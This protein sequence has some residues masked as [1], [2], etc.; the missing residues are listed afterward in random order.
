MKFNKNLI[1]FLI[2]CNVCFTQNMDIKILHGLR[3]PELLGD[4]IKLEKNTFKAFKKMQKAA[5]DDGV[6]LKIVSAYRSYERQKLIWNNKFEKYTTEFGLK[7]KNAIDEII[8]FSTIPGTSRHHWGTEIDIIDGKFTKE[9]DVLIEKKFMEGGI[10]YELK[11]WLD[12]N[13]E[14]FGF[15]IA[16][17]NDPQRKGFEHEPWHYSY[18]PVSK[19]FLESF[20]KSD[21]KKIIKNDEIRGSEYFTDDFIKKY[22]KEYILDINIILKK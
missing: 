19:K 12:K 14:K 15:Y 4:S 18:Y 6:D 13:S 1:L 2:F 9:K 21:L 22:I 17:N 5:K 11:K 20:L 8:R 16:Y 3:N 7:P 10:F